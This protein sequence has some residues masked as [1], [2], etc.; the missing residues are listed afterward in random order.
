M[1]EATKSK[2]SPS[3][4]APKSGF[5]GALDKFFEISKRGS[6]IGT[7]LRGGL[8]IFMT[9]VYIVILNP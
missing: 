4:S 5:S 7:E 6:T 2:S 9:M 8:V 1:A 3:K